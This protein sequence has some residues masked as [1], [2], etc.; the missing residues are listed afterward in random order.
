MINEHC[1]CIRC[2]HLFDRF[3]S[4]VRLILLNQILSISKHRRI[5][6]SSI[7][8]IEKNFWMNIS[9]EISSAAVEKRDAQLERR[10]FAPAALIK[11]H[12]E[13]RRCT[14]SVEA[15][16]AHSRGRCTL[17]AHVCS[18]STP[19]VRAVS[20]GSKE[21]VGRAILRG[22]FARGHSQLTETN[23]WFCMHKVLSRAKFMKMRVIFQPLSLLS[24]GGIEI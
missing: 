12:G 20:G 11:H 24:V 7:K 4:I 21:R 18:V 10:D 6:Y 2:K 16:C 15:P 19:R 8:N 9:P 22:T 3:N 23:P 5:Y 13:C 14:I 1:I 17:G